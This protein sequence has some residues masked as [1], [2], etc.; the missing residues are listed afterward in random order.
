MLSNYIKKYFMDKKISQHEIEK[1][2][3]ISQSKLS[4]VY[5]NKRKLTADELFN[6]AIE[7]NLNL[8]DIK[9]EIKSSLRN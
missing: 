1:R 6:I 5:N 9:K 8:E 3:G 4:L 2:T 7:F